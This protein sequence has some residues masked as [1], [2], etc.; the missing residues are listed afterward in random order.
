[1]HQRWKFSIKPNVHSSSKSAD[2]DTSGISIAFQFWSLL[3]VGILS[4]ICSLFVFYRYLSN[5]TRLYALHNHFI[6]LLMMTNIILILT[7]FSWMLDSL[8]QSGRA[9]SATSPFS[10][11]WWTVDFSLYNTQTLILAWASIERHILIFHSKM[12]STRKQKFY[13]HY[14]S[15]TILIIYLFTFYIGVIF[16]PPCKNEFNFNAVEC[17]LNPCYLSIQFLV[18]WDLIIHNA[19]PTL[20][21]AIFS[22]PLLYRIISHKKT[23]STTNSMAKISTVTLSLP[24]VA[25]LSYLPN[26]TRQHR[27]I[28]PILTFLQHRRIYTRN[29]TK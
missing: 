10:M 17:G 3:I 11:I 23:T 8:R 20:I 18:L 7:D 28:V 25:C 24:Y 15:Y 2:I 16:L 21:I 22:L 29:I 5:H 6:L 4:L 9:L 1:M 12:I 27:R 13:Y 26:G 14:L 19:L